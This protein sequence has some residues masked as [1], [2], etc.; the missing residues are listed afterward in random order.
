MSG[1]S[2]VAATG[3]A[4]LFVAT[5]TAQTVFVVDGQNRPG[6]HFTDL[7]PAEA[8]AQ[9][10]DT[11]LL[12]CDGGLYHGIATQKAL[13]ITGDASGIATITGQG[14]GI[15]ISGIPAGRDF[16]LQNVELG[17]Y[18]ATTPRLVVQACAGRVHLVRVHVY[19]YL[20]APA[21]DVSL[22]GAVTV[23]D[24][25]LQG[26]PGLLAHNATVAASATRCHG[27]GGASATLL[28]A[29]G[30]VLIDSSAWCTDVQASGGNAW[31]T[32][33]PAAAIELVNANLAMTGSPN[34][35][36]AQAG[37]LGSSATPGF[38]AAVPAIR[39]QTSSVRLDP[40]VVLG[41][42]GGAA[43]IVGAAA[44]TTSIPAFAMYG[45]TLLQVMADLGAATAEA[46]L[47]GLPAAPLPLPG[48]EGRLWL[49]PNQMLVMPGVL[50]GYS[51]FYEYLLPP[52]LLL[53]IQVVSLQPNSVELSTP[54]IVLS[55]P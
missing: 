10:G 45:V 18:G 55:R 1:P 33:A 9:D 43:A 20:G 25:E 12:R 8:A 16:V 36:R 54:A 5:C 30:I 19:D 24:C 17:S 14:P 44:T 21:L 11:I 2:R 49:D 39:G 3:V 15:T 40:E 27:Q 41:P 48:V 53:A 47:V 13:S 7:P 52:G 6:T 31:H 46:T 51:G 22:C 4:F 26:S 34:G 23:R 37:F 29:A 50:D 42:T 35:A 32:N 28:P 38:T